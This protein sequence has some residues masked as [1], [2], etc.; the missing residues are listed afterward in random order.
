MKKKNLKIL[1]VCLLTIMVFLMVLLIDRVLVNPKWKITQYS[2]DSGAQAMFYTITS[3]K[4]D[5]III[6]GGH[7]ENAGK[8]RKVIEE[9]GN[10]VDIWILT[11]PH[12]DHIG[13]FNEIYAQPEGIEI[14]Y[15]Y[16]NGLD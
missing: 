10:H 3:D 12:P 8:V 13:A 14:D 7:T 11:H 9:Y 6:D 5:L 1:L 15:I 2:D 16:D 4:K